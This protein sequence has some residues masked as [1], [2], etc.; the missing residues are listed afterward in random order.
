MDYTCQHCGADLDQGDVLE[1]FLLEYEGDYIK[2]IESAT[3]YGW[4]ETNNIH[5][6]RSIIV[7]P[8]TGLQYTICPDCE[9]KDP[10]LQKSK[11]QR[12]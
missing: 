3:L 10:L 8:D 12:E 7:Q 4:T 1:Y 9:K 5:F 6:N 11:N 2:A